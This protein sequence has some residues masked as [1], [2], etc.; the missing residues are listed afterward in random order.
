MSNIFQQ[1][2]DLDGFEP[3][4]AL[5]NAL[6][7][8]MRRYA[9]KNELD[10]SRPSTALL[11]FSLFLGIVICSYGVQLPRFDWDIAKFSSIRGLSK[12][13]V[14]E[15]LSLLLQIAAAMPQ[16][17][18][19][20]DLEEHINDYFDEVDTLL[21]KGQQLFSNYG[22]P[23]IVPERFDI[24]LPPTGMNY[25][26]G[27]SYDILTRA[28]Y[29]ASNPAAFPSLGN[30]K[31][32]V[33]L[34]EKQNVLRD[35]LQHFVPNSNGFTSKLKSELIDEVTAKQIRTLI[36]NK[37]ARADLNLATI[38]QEQ[39]IQVLDYISIL[40]NVELCHIMAS[41][42][43][44]VEHRGMREPLIACL[45]EYVRQL[46]SQHAYTLNAVNNGKEVNIL[47]QLRAYLIIPNS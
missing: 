19:D 36:L 33:N 16:A 5:W 18:L 26:L 39:A 11:I 13:A 25:T 7:P 34:Y 17:E 1:I 28:K 15:Y 3:N 10:F 21:Q 20:L 14:V 23:G 40:D 24:G 32:V 41:F 27:I 22:K 46:R 6:D 47:K 29:E 44:K 37:I 42:V 45:M 35:F 38:S 8:Y 30:V 31:Y 4:V 9:L 2:P 12:N 43:D